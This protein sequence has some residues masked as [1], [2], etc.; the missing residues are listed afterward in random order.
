MYMYMHIHA[1]IIMIYSVILLLIFSI[2]QGELSKSLLSK[3]RHLRQEREV[4]ACT[5]YIQWNFSIVDTSSKC[6]D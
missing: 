5:W 2:N 6:P 1:I 4:Y 3:A